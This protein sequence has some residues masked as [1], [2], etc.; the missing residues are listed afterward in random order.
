MT[1]VAQ[2]R[3]LVLWRARH[4]AGL[5]S[6]EIGVSA[7]RIP[8]APDGASPVRV[9]RIPRTHAL[10]LASPSRSR[11][12]A[13][14]VAKPRV[15][16]TRMTSGRSLTSRVIAADRHAWQ[17]GMTLPA[18]LLYGTTRAGPQADLVRLS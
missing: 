5:A 9:R 10:V 16:D 3:A 17:P 1:D 13:S 4:E 7:T 14:I 6:A 18:S 8:R 12:R 15:P 2:E 11:P